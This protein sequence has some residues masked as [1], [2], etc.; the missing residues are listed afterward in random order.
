MLCKSK[1]KLLTG[2]QGIKM[3]LKFYSRLKIAIPFFLLYSTPNVSNASCLDDVTAN[4]QLRGF[5]DTASV[6]E[7]LVKLDKKLL[8]G[9]ASPTWQDI[10]NVTRALTQLRTEKRASIQSSSIDSYISELKTAAQKL[11]DDPVWLTKIGLNKEA[12]LVENDLQSLASKTLFW[13][14]IHFINKELPKELR[15]AIQTPARAERFVKLEKD[16]LKIMNNQEKLF[17]KYFASSSGFSSWSSYRVAIQN[18]ARSDNSIKTMLAM[19][20][21]EEVEF[22]MARPENARWWT[23]RVGFQNQHVTGSSRGYSGKIGRN[24]AEAGMSNHT[25]EQFS[26]LSD[27]LKPRYGYLHRTVKEDQELDSLHYGSDYFFFDKN[28]LKHRVSFTIDDSLNAYNLKYRGWKSGE[29]VNA[30]EYFL[31]FIPWSRR[32]I[33][34]SL[35]DPHDD[36][37]IHQTHSSKIGLKTQDQSSKYTELQYWGNVDLSHVKKFAFTEIPPEGDFLKALNKNKVEIWDATNRRFKR[38]TAP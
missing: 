11:K 16:A 10:Q 27:E 33:L 14:Y 25:Y 19:L 20:D 8:S 15:I 17:E 30:Q 9:S 35:I 21:N 13:D 34:A 5:N 1:Q 29:V 12:I 3:L 2:I 36:S 22:A 28:K 7:Y 24:A 32:S 26:Q 6:I 38:W 31:N 37:G 23:E 4:L 18:A